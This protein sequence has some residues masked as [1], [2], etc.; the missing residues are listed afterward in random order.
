MLH[1]TETNNCSAVL[2]TKPQSG[3]ASVSAEDT[4]P[5]SSGIAMGHCF[6]TSTLHD[7]CGGGCIAEEGNGGGQ[8][9]ITNADILTPVYWSDIQVGDLLYLKNN[10]KI[11]ADVIL[12]TSSDEASGSGA[13]YIETAN[14]DGETNLKIRV[15]A[16]A[17]VPTWGEAE[18]VTQENRP[19][20]G[21]HWY[22]QDVRR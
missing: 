5:D 22:P 14:I 17:S 15:S 21:N 13:V 20:T 16:L 18:T 6:S 1:I 10:D 7:S 8:R 4:Y 2:L 11:P 12:L 19:L 9:Q 3:H